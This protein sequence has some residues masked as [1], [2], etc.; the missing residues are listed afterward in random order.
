MRKLAE[1]LH[2]RGEINDAYALASAIADIVQATG[3]PG[4]YASAPFGVCPFCGDHEAVIVVAGKQYAVC[5]E[6]HIYW[7]I[8]ADYLGLRQATNEILQENRQLLTSYT[9]IATTEAFPS[10]VCHCCGLSIA[11]SPWCI[12]PSATVNAAP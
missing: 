11:H 1:A 7:Y 2:T 4:F 3:A 9:Q 6:H 12:V 5:H 8:G 10:T